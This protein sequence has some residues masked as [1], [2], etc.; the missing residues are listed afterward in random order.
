MNPPIVYGICSHNDIISGDYNDVNNNIDF[1]ENVIL[2]RIM[3]SPMNDQ[4]HHAFTD[5]SLGLSVDKGGLKD[6][7]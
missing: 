5:L 6:F 3:L 4:P 1:N 7:S 2:I